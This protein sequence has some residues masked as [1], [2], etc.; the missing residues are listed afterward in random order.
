MMRQILR[1]PNRF[2]YILNMSADALTPTARVFYEQTRFKMAAS[3][4]LASM[5]MMCLAYVSSYG[6]ESNSA[7]YVKKTVDNL[8][9]DNLEQAQVALAGGYGKWARAFLNLERGSIYLFLLLP[10]GFAAFMF[11]VAFSVFI[12]GAIYISPMFCG[13]P[14]EKKLLSK[15]QEIDSGECLC[16]VACPFTWSET[17]KFTSVM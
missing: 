13:S 3:I 4:F 5:S 11:F 9:D 17:R 16:T 8:H 15:P 10:P 1:N 12:T 2:C 7:N 14:M 6:G